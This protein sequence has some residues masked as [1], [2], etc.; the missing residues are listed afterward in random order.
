MKLWRQRAYRP[1]DHS[2]DGMVDTASRKVVWVPGKFCMRNRCELLI[3]PVTKNGPK[4]LLGPDQKVCS[5]LF[6]WVKWTRR[7]R[8]YRGR[9]RR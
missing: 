4:R 2:G 9:D 8:R 6:I 3:N 1:T 5:R 7:H